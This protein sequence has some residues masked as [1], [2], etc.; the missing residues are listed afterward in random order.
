[1]SK[2]EEVV[3]KLF[4]PTKDKDLRIDYPELAE[5]DEF[6]NLEPSMVKFC[7]YVGNR[8][9]PLY[10]LKRED[11]VLKALSILFP[12]GYERIPQARELAEGNFSEDIVRGIER[13]TIFNPENRLKAMLISDYTFN[14]LQQLIYVDDKVLK[15][16]DFDEKKKYSDLLIK[17]QSSLPDIIKNLESGFGVK[18]VQKTTGKKVLVGMK[19]LG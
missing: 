10:N 7:W 3:I 9:S 16:M 11:K 4:N 18:V 13:M 14:Q 5:M 8:T 1:M 19:N 6:K 17:V 12:R 2:E 15:M